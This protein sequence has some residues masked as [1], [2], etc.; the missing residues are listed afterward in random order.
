MKPDFSHALFA[1][2]TPWFSGEQGEPD[3]ESLATWVEQAGLTAGSGL[4]L[5]LGVP[6]DDGLGYEE[7]IWQSGQVATRPWNWH[8]YFNGLIWLLYPR[9]KAAL[10][11]RHWKAMA[12][13]EG[14]RGAVRDS[15]THLDE[16]G[17]LVT[18]SS[19]YLLELLSNFQWKKLFWEERE[20]LASHMEFHIF[21]HGT[22]EQLLAPFRGLTA[23]AV[24]YEVPESWHQLSREAQQHAL[25]ERLAT[26]IEAGRYVLPQDLQPLPLLGI[27]GL[28]PE[29]SVS[30]YY[31]DTWQFRPGRN[32]EARL[33][34]V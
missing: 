9:S 20:L 15:M 33:R 18:S 27:P 29:N 3:T 6:P 25:D 28:V 10:N 30:E 22:Y 5:S 34:S 12:D 7:R 31:D 14:A 26:D 23:K 8:D 17:I 1:P 16:C 32:R 21:G 4:P 19:P 24:L 2:L 13:E 11:R